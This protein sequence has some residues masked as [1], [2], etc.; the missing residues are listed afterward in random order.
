FYA[1]MGKE[2]DGLKIKIPVIPPRLKI[3]TATSGATQKSATE[4]L[5]VP[6]D[7]MP[8]IGGL[9]VS[10]SGSSLVNLKGPMRYLQQYPYGCLEQRLSRIAPKLLDPEFIRILGISGEGMDSL[11]KTV[12]ESIGE[13]YKYQKSDGGFGYWP[14][15]KSNEYITAFALQ[16]FKKA[17]NRGYRVDEKSVNRAIKYSA[18]H[19][20]GF[21]DK[22]FSTKYR[23]GV[24]SSLLYSLALWDRG[25]QSRLSYLFEHRNDM[26]LFGRAVLM[27]TCHI[28]GKSGMENTLARELLNNIKVSPRSAHFEESGDPGLRWL[29]SSSLRTSAIILEALLSCG[30]E[31]PQA[32]LVA[33]WIIDR[34]KNGR[35]S[36]TQEN[37]YAIYALNEY[38]RKYE[39]AVPDYVVRVILAG[40]RILEGRIRGRNSDVLTGEVPM[41]K[42]PRGKTLPVIFEKSGRGILKYAMILSYA[43]TGKV[44]PMDE[45]ITV[46][47]SIRSLDTGKPVLPGR[48]FKLGET[49]IIT[50]H[51]LTPQER[52]YVVLDDPLPGGFEVINTTFTTASREQARRLNEFRKRE[53]KKTGRYWYGGTFRHWE[54]YD[55]RIVLFADRLEA[56]EHSFSYMVRAM[57]SGSF[58]RPE[59]RSEEMY[60]PE[61]FGNTGQEWVRI[62]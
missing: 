45:G 41:V 43:P 26:P 47:R 21:K 14:T 5:F 34:Q 23:L 32:P 61:I 29:F 48:S 10:T 31:F 1:T 58:F 12:Q 28:M 13:L 15:G 37:L 33:Q 18:K 4:Q 59:A 55:D 44:L 60:N 51:V 2:K 25:D 52:A 42:I 57:R 39:K 17:K 19:L 20:A 7:V 24:E 38:Y 16:V 35:W 3:T 27:K 49:Y 8:D 11:R 56:G 50:L 62:K 9:N 22:N 54:I 6:A 36:N 40:K 46:L 53:K 30:H